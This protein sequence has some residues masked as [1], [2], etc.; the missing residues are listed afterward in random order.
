[1]PDPG[2]VAAAREVVGMHLVRL[3]EPESTVEFLR[4]GVMM[5][6]GAIGKGYAIERAAGILV[7]GGVTS[8]LIHGGTST[9]HAIGAPPGE[10]AWT[11][12]LPRPEAAGQPLWCD[13]PAGAPDA[14]AVL[15]TVQLR[16]EA[17]SVSA[18]WGRAFTAGGIRY[19]HVLDPR[20]GHPVSEAVLAAVVTA[21]ATE[22]DALSTALLVVGGAGHD[23]IAAL[24]PGLRSVLLCEDRNGSRRI[25]A[26]GIAVSP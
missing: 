5:D 15:T 26:R 25:R 21:S 10:N 8:G 22:T 2:E 14:A 11:I 20:C 23:R 1:V 9:V 24:R 3:N 6:L 4:E 12:A 19:G 18:V 7:D 17:L 16:D 13:R